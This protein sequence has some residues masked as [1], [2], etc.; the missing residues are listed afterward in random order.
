MS[1]NEN[2]L[3]TVDIAALQKAKFADDGFGDL[4]GPGFG[5]FLPYIQ[6]CGSSTDLAKR[7]EIAVGNYALI[8][9]SGDKKEHV[10]LG[11]NVI[12]IPVAWRP[13]AMN[14]KTNPVL[15]SF[16]P[17]SPLFQ[18]LRKTAEADSQSGC[19]FGPEFLLWIPGHGFA[20]FHMGSKTARNE[21]RSVQALLPGNDGR[22]KTAN[23]SAQFIKTEKYSWHGPKCVISSQVAE[24]PPA[25]L[26]LQ[27][28]TDFLNPADSKPPETAAP[29]VVNQ[30]R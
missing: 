22:L 4:S 26:M 23:L 20:T 21:A 27:T 12:C 11:K 3:A 9:G 8:I 7:G 17:A 10:D 6:L 29:E 16:N 19:M 13:K 1:A 15:A 28:V 5:A 2:A 14:A 24:Q 30:D 25:E 18:Q